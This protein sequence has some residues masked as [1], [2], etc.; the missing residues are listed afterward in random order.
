[1]GAQAREATITVSA[2]DPTLAAE[3]TEEVTIRQPGGPE[4]SFS[5]SPSQISG[6]SDLGEL[7]RTITVE[8]NVPWTAAVNTG[9]DWVDITSGDDGTSP[10]SLDIAAN[11]TYSVRTATITVTPGGDFANLAVSVTI[12]QDAAPA[13]LTSPANGTQLVISYDNASET[14]LTFEWSNR[15]GVAAELIVS[16]NADLSNG[17]SIDLGTGTSADFTHTQLQALIEDPSLGLKRYYKNDLYWSVKINGTDISPNAPRA[18]TLS[19]QRVMFYNVE[20][21]PVAVIETPAY[22]AVWMA[23]NLKTMTFKDGTSLRDGC[24]GSGSAA[25]PGAPAS[26]AYDYG[27]NGYNINPLP[28]DNPNTGYFYFTD[29]NATPNWLNDVDIT[30]PDPTGN[31][32][33]G[34]TLPTYTDYNNLYTAANAAPDGDKVLLDTEVYGAGYGA[35]GLNFYDT[36]FAGENNYYEYTVG[37]WVTMILPEKVLKSGTALSYVY[38][39]L[40]HTH[41]GTSSDAYAAYYWRSGVVRFKYIGDDN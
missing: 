27:T 36:G 39:R 17:V 37:I 29:W 16:K 20:V 19:G 14:A 31:A 4:A 9:D 26:T 5:V 2:N 12:T 28:G 11:P 24:F 25:T 21:Y 40:D 1:V 30:Q 22:S 33:D 7:T 15:N 23:R 10:I 18:L 41:S 38:N 35:W 3:F 6:V 32:P 34:W 8:S 13:P